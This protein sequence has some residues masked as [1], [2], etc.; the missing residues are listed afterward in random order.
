MAIKWN[1]SFPNVLQGLKETQFQRKVSWIALIGGLV[2]LFHEESALPHVN[3]E[4]R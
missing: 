2:A 1:G 4:L 3:H